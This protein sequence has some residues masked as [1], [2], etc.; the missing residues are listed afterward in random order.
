MMPFAQEV[1]QSEADIERGIAPVNDF[2]IEQNQS[3]VP[4]ENVL[5]TVVAV[6]QRKAAATCV[7]DE[8]IDER[9]RG[10]DLIG[11]IRV[12]GLDAERLEEP[13]V[14]EYLAQWFFRFRRATVNRSEQSRELM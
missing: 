4:D 8:L 14:V 2:V 6:H 5:G 12:I 9:A 7:G 11:G 13:A 1:R 3:S 10:G